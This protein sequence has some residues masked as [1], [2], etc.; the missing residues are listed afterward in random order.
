MAKT[1]DDTLYIACVLVPMQGHDAQLVLGTFATSHLTSLDRRANC[2]CILI[3]PDDP[4]M[5]TIYQYVLS[6]GISF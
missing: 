2:S 5:K 6:R 3:V 1:N 4:K